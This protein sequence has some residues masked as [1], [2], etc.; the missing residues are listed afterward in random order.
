MMK[1][2][3]TGISGKDGSVAIAYT[4]DTGYA[5]KILLCTVIAVFSLLILTNGKITVRETP[6][7]ASLFLY[8]ENHALGAWFTAKAC[9]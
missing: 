7:K 8:K 5:V 9:R 3:I 6:V 1:Y 2:G 4:Q